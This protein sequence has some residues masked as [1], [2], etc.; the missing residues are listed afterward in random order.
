MYLPRYNTSISGVCNGAW[1]SGNSC[2]TPSTYWQQ[3]HDIASISITPAVTEYHLTF[4]TH[5]RALLQLIRSNQG[6]EY[7]CL[8]NRIM[9]IAHVNG[10]IGI[11]P[12]LI[13]GPCR[14]AHQLSILKDVLSTIIER[15]DHEMA[16]HVLDGLHEGI[17]PYQ[18]TV[19][20]VAWTLGILQH[21][22]S[23]HDE[24]VAYLGF[25]I[26]RLAM[27]GGR[28]NNACDFV[29]WLHEHNVLQS[30]PSERRMK[31][32]IKAVTCVAVSIM[33]D[34]QIDEL[35]D[36]SPLWAYRCMHSKYAVQLNKR[37]KCPYLKSIIQ[38]SVSHPYALTLHST[39]ETTGARSA[40]SFLIDWL[41]IVAWP[42]FADMLKF[43][44]RESVDR[45]IDFPT[46]FLRHHMVNTI[47]D[48]VHLTYDCATIVGPCTPEELDVFEELR[49]RYLCN[50]FTFSIVT[51]TGTTEVIPAYNS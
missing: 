5:V 18:P 36:L 4:Q 28:I 29:A 44:N 6:A 13:I 8:A 43:N 47:N 15:M 10:D 21:A 7:A 14:D 46:G 3:T 32:A 50:D 25:G 11:F 30:L 45:V 31:R 22:F 34:T 40:P 2:A 19:Y 39:S 49:I 20:D 17:L 1:N 35:L 37:C 26:G 9:R 24:I 42:Y 27:C 48:I 33:N 23:S 41:A 51:L 12:E 38:A 16:M